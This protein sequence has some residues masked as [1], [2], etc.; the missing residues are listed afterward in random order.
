MYQLLVPNFARVLE[1]CYLL[2]RA[3]SRFVRITDTLENGLIRQME[4][5]AFDFNISNNAPILLQ[6]LWPANLVRVEYYI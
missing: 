4:E 3:E 5:F 1:H 2:K 6:I